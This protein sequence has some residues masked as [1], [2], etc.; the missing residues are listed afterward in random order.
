MRF[1]VLFA[2]PVPG[3]SVADERA[4]LRSCVEQAVCAEAYGFHRAWVMEHHGLSGYGHVS[5]PDVLLAWIGARTS[6]LRL[7]VGV[8]MPAAINHPVRVAERVALLDV[9]SGGRV[10]VVAA[11]GRSACEAALFG[12]DVSKADEERDLSL[13]RIARMWNDVSPE[14]PAVLPSPVQL[15]HPPLFAA[16]GDVPSARRAGALGL[17]A[18]ALGFGGIG[19]VPELLGAYR[20]GTSSRSESIVL[21]PAEQFSV[22]CPT[23]VLRDQGRAEA[24]GSRGERY[25]RQAAKHWYGGGPVATGDD[26]GSLAVAGAYGTSEVAIEFV[27]A[28]QRADVDEVV[29]FVQMGTVSPDVCLETLERWGADVLPR[30]TD[31]PVDAARSGSNARL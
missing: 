5:A 24:I 25:F 3:G 19:S 4:V 20:A 11:G 28:L 30:F 7:G 13:A 6:T 16:C 9:L 21:S 29:C 12:N 2:A 8:A 22:L 10:D 1:S 14:L 26:D 31:N 18:L 15:P 23:V 27:D 17:G